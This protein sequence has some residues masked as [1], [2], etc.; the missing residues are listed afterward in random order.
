MQNSAYMKFKSNFYHKNHNFTIE[1]EKI[2]D[3][4]PIEKIESSDENFTKITFNNESNIQTEMDNKKEGN[5]KT[6]PTL[7]SNLEHAKNESDLSGTTADISPVRKG[8]N[9]S[10]ILFKIT[11]N[12]QAY[13]TKYFI[14]QLMKV[15][16]RVKKHLFNTSIITHKANNK[17]FIKDSGNLLTGTFKS[18]FGQLPKKNTLMYND[19]FTDYCEVVS[20]KVQKYQKYDDQNIQI[21]NYLIFKSILLGKGSYSHV[22]YAKNIID[23]KEYVKNE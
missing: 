19:I 9:E 8:E 18:R 17:T 11:P 1:E 2:S 6:T 7:K 12:Q 10:K 22:Y 5:I 15:L 3:L 16:L 21:N 23:G 14:Y 4:S 13:I 20:P